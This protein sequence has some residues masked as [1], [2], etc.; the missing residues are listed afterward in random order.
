MGGNRIEYFCLQ[1]MGHTWEIDDYVCMLLNR[2]PKFMRVVYLV[3]VSVYFFW[4][5]NNDEVIGWIL[6]VFLL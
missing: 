3:A 5:D 4:N 2:L 6:T 1:N